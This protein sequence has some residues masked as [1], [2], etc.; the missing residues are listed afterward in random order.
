MSAAPS[1]RRRARRDEILDAACRV[2]G[3]VGT[4]SLRVEDVAG[5]AGV[6]T[7]LL[8]YY[9]DDRTALLTAAFRHANTELVSIRH[10]PAGTG[11][12]RLTRYLLAEL[13][14]DQKTAE[15]WSLWSEMM[16]AAVF[17]PSL[18]EPI[19]EAYASWIGH[20]GDLITTGHADGSIGPQVDPVSTA[21]RLCSLMDGLGSRS[22]MGGIDRDRARSITLSALDLELA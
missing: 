13:E 17:D 5:E 8:Y 1:T 11:R 7:S 2:I 4:R 10:D 21:E 18:R 19:N 9:F 14:D 3:R 15:N 12:E 6:A 16:A 22:I 20:V